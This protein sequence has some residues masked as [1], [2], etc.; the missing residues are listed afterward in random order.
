MA[1]PVLTI[2]LEGSDGPKQVGRWEAF[3][4]KSGLAAPERLELRSSFASLALLIEGARAEVAHLLVDGKVAKLQRLG[5]ALVSRVQLCNDLEEHRIAFVQ[6]PE[7]AFT[8]DV[9]VTHEYRVGPLDKQMLVS[10]WSKDS[11]EREFI[12]FQKL[13][14]PQQQIKYDEFS[15]GMKFGSSD[16]L[17]ST[18]VQLVGQLAELLRS[19]RPNDFRADFA[20]KVAAGLDK[21]AVLTYVKDD[22]RRLTQDPNGSIR[23]G[24]LAYT[25]DI[26]VRHLAPSARVD[27]GALVAL[28]EEC[29]SMLVRSNAPAVVPVLLRHTVAELRWRYRV[30]GYVSSQDIHSLLT[31]RMHAARNS[32]LQNLLRLLVAC[33][34][35]RV[36]RDSADQSLLWLKQGIRD[37]DLFELSTYYLVARAF[38]FSDEQGRSAKPFL[39]DGTV[40]V[41]NGNRLG[42]LAQFR[43]AVSGWREAT[44][45]PSDY[46]PDIVVMLPG[47]LPVILDAKFSMGGLEGHPL[48]SDSLKEVQAYLDEFDLPGAILLV[49]KVLNLASLNASGYVELL[50]KNRSG[51][52]RLIIGVPLQDPEDQA[53]QNAVRTAVQQ[54]AA[55]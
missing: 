32:E 19:T 36:G 14:S 27:V 48:A 51:Q 18:L 45:Q 11:F 37:F 35:Q 25:T 20:I 9:S 43:A 22:P 6:V 8:I 5:N 10:K 50:G 52:N 24:G 49:P 47:R 13:F 40:S 23:F 41:L 39:S 31:R 21:D 3:A 46:H 15:R 42:G 16:S 30:R 17:N 7:F 33:A 54:V 1:T 29:S 28:L 4:L 26:D 38:G 55:L 34:A 12:R 44:G 53:T 2:V